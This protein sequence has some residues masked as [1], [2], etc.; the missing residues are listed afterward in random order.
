MGIS[1]VYELNYNNFQVLHISLKDTEVQ[2]KTSNKITLITNLMF[3][4]SKHNNIYL[5]VLA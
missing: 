1:F 5:Y 2:I 4:P 3:E